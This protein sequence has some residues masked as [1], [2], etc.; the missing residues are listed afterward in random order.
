MRHRNTQA[1]L[2]FPAIAVLVAWFP[3]VSA[4]AGC[5]SFSFT[6]D[7]YTVKEQAGSVTLTVVRDDKLADSSVQY[8]TVNGTATAPKD[9]KK[10]TGSTLEYTGQ[11][12]QKQ[13]QVTIE[14]DN[15]DEA[16]EAFTVVLDGGSGCAVNPN[17]QYDNATVTIQDND[18]KAI[19]QPT[20]TPTKTSSPKPKPSTASAS[21]SLTP[22]SPSP[23][24]T[25]SA[26]PIAA[27]ES[28]DGGLSGGALAGIVAATV[29][30]GGGAAFWVRRRFLT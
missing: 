27:A 30:L 22:T 2:I 26:S 24:P 21:P 15:A 5:H 23:T 16:N 29:V 10:E 6:Q 18:E 11:D 19:V 12:L 4:N 20:P 3:I 14:D 25:T 13:F 9:Y 8:H 1:R 28:G 17:F 7:T